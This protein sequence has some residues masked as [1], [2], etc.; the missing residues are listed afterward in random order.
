[1]KPKVKKTLKKKTQA[2]R[3]SKADLSEISLVKNIL[4]KPDR[5]KYIRK[6][7]KAEGCVFCRSAKSVSLSSLCVYKSKHSMIVLNK[8]PYNS[9]HILVLP[10]RHCGDLFKFSNEEYLDLMETLRVASRAVTDVY[11]PP[12]IWA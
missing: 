1:M 9:G 4:F 10:Q 5:Y 8:F 2:K 7:I 3:K 12:L 11:R 6:E